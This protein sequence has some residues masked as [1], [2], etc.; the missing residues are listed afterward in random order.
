MAILKPEARA[1][2]IKLTRNHSTAAVWAMFPTVDQN[3][4]LR[5]E[6]GLPID[7]FEFSELLNTLDRLSPPPV[8][9]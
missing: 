7:P 8:E 5:A 4:V 9:S 6:A 2:L 1:R 3:S